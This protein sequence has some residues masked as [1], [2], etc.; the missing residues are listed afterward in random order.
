V[1]L[2]LRALV[3]GRD[4]FRLPPVTL[5]VAPGRLVALIGPNGVGKT[6]LL[7]TLANLIPPLSGSF[8]AGGTVAWLPP[9]GA[10]DA[11]FSALHLA[12][13]GRA[14]TRGWSAGLSRDDRAAARAALE[15]LG[16]AA[17]AD[18]P[19]DRLSS[20]QQQLVLLARLL[21]QD[22]VVCLLD[23]PLALLDP[24]HAAEVEQAMRALADEGRIV[25]AS[26]HALA[27]AAR[28]DRVWT[29]GPDGLEDL[30]PAEA[31]AA[32]RVARLYDLPPGGPPLF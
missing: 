31:L 1:S 29:L 6:T 25:V 14:S 24:R 5:E 10:V 11:A 3:A 27:F 12:A 4:R 9:P 19:F 23:E 8:E 13:L 26:T 7:R 2:S 15:R 22:A 20:G 28:C 21:V 32:A 17:L 18:H 16:I 30:A